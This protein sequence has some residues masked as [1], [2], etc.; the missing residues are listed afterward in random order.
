MSSA[1]IRAREAGLGDDERHA[2]A[3]LVT[4]GRAA[5][6]RDLHPDG[7]A[8]AFAAWCDAIEAGTATLTVW[9]TEPAGPPAPDGTQPHVRVWHPELRTVAP[10]ERSAG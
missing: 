4:H 3:W 8:D 10:G 7:E 9:R 2:L 1:A 6:V 5:S